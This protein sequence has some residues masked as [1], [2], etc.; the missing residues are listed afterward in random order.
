MMKLNKN[1]SRMDQIWTKGK[2][3]LCDPDQFPSP[4]YLIFEFKF[5]REILSKV[6]Q[7]DPGKR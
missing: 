1:L 5:L 4:H 7:S 6:K 3:F 2:S